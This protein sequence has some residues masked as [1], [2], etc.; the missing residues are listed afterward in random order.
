MLKGL[1]V[2]V[3]GMRGV[4]FNIYYRG[5]VS[6]TSEEI[7]QE[8]GSEVTSIRGVNSLRVV[9]IDDTQPYKVAISVNFDD[10]TDIKSLES[11][12]AGLSFVSSAGHTG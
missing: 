7:K 10:R 5:S 6:R 9:A 12:I 2:L 4:K 3:C 11:D 1:F 8:V